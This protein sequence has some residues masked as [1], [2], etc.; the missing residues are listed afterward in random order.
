M[1]RWQKHP[2]YV[3]FLLDYIPGHE[4][5][6]IIEAFNDKFGILL[7]ES[8]IGNFKHTY[9]VKSGTHGGCFKKGLIP[10]NKGKPMS[11]EVY[12][13]VKGSFFQKGHVP[14]TY[15]KVGSERITVDGYTEIKIADPNKWCL[16]QRVV[17]EEFYHEKLKPN[18]VV[19]FLDGNKQNFEIS[20]LFKMNRSSLV[21]FNQDHLYGGD[22][23]ISKAAAVLASL[24][25]KMSE[26]KQKK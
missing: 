2:E 8:K 4:E 3:A 5:R 20:N 19:V 15:R 1:I 16:K 12:E 9:G 25:G 13:R 17:W 21:R 18:E 26:V 6:E 23:D 24:K 10:H 7:S 11:P 22:R 14:K